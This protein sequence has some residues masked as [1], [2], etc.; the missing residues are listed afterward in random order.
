MIS[1]LRQVHL[2][3]AHGVSRNKFINT[4][5]KLQK[6]RMKHRNI[7]KPSNITKPDSN[8]CA[9]VSCFLYS[10]NTAFYVRLI[11]LIRFIFLGS[12]RSFENLTLFINRV[13]KINSDSKDWQLVISIITRSNHLELR[14][15]QKRWTIW[16]MLTSV[17]FKTRPSGSFIS[18]IL[19]ID[20]ARSRIWEGKKK[21]KTEE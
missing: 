4:I 3:A 17:L 16:T 15:W 6:F 18:A 13:W 9:Q 10:S 2:P 11:K 12:P 8:N 14:H 7:H 20:F 5:Q 1:Y 19:R 21:K